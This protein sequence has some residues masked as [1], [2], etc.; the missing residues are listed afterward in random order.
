MNMNN[1]TT[2]MIERS[3]LQSVQESINIGKHVLKRKLAVYADKLKHFEETMHMDTRTFM[4]LFEQGELGDQKEWL[5]WDHVA[6][7]VKALQKKLR[8]LE[9]LQYES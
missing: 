6:S 5:E 4:T 2:I 8:D 1:Y 9:T 3:A 7:V